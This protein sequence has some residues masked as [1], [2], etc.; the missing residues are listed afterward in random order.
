MQLAGARLKLIRVRS[1]IEFQHATHGLDVPYMH[2]NVFETGPR[3]I[4][5][6]GL[7]QHLEGGGQFDVQNAQTRTKASTV[8]LETRG[9]LPLLEAVDNGHAGMYEPQRV[10][11]H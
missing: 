7:E 4:V 10:R 5:G 11:K 6:K 1:R 8:M 2:P 3:A 9:F